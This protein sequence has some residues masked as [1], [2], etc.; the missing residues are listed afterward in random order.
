MIER[1]EDVG[2]GMRE[3]RRKVSNAYC[4]KNIRTSGF[5]IETMPEDA[6]DDFAS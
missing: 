4:P 6:L 2:F 3:V 5:A 1:L